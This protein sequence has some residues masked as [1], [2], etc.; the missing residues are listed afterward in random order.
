LPT[1]ELKAGKY[2]GKSKGKA[3]TEGQAAGITMPPAV[4]DAVKAAGLDVK[5]PFAWINANAIE[6]R[7]NYHI[8]KLYKAGKIG[9]AYS[10][11]D[12]RH[13]FAV[14]EYKKDKDIVRVSKLLNHANVSITQNYLRGLGVSL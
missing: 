5:K 7:I 8:G 9:A 1:L 10:C 13:Y 4:I 3:L 12:F 11:H 2:H 6:R 14:Q